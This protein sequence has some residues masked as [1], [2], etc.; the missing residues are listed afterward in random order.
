MNRRYDPAAL[1]IMLAAV[2]L[3]LMQWIAVI[4][5]TSMPSGVEF[6]QSW[7]LITLALVYAIYLTA[8]NS[9]G[10]ADGI[11]NFFTSRLNLVFPTTALAYLSTQWFGGFHEKYDQVAWHN[12]V[13]LKGFWMG[14]IASSHPS[15]TNPFPSVAYSWWANLLQF[16]VDH[17]V[18]SWF[19]YVVIASEIAIALAFITAVMTA[20]FR[21]YL[22]VPAIGALLAMTYHY[23]FLMSGSAGVNA[24]MPYL[25]GFVSICLVGSLVADHLPRAKETIILEPIA[26]PTAKETV[27]TNGKVSPREPVGTR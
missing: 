25:T 2:V 13:A 19:G 9:S 12:G 1:V 23:F 15:A 17:S 22:A 26:A 16:M 27:P 24:L 11:R 10:I 8:R 3:A 5:K 18:Y 14:A 7:I 21:P 6:V 20:F 4:Q